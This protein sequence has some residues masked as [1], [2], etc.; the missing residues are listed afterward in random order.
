M[1]S[2]FPESIQFWVNGRW[3]RLFRGK[4]YT[5]RNIKALRDAGLDRKRAVGIGRSVAQSG[6]VPKRLNR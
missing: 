6:V 2:D 1:L 4:E 5:G 3:V